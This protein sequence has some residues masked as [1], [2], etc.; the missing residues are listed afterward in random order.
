M[1]T[2]VDLWIEGGITPAI[3]K[4]VRDLTEM[5]T[6]N[7]KGIKVRQ[8]KIDERLLI[9]TFNSRPGKAEYLA[10]E[11]LKS[12]SLYLDNYSDITVMFGRREKGLDS[13]ADRIT[14]REVVKKI[15]EFYRLLDD[16]NWTQIE[17]LLPNKIN[18]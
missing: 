13:A 12:Y 2:R 7:K 11:I 1:E 15:R 5:N 18:T 4:Q 9:I 8:D 17:L 10:D 16:K 14:K 6:T 3:K